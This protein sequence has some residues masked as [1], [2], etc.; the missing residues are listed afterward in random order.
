MNKT[1]KINGAAVDHDASPGPD[2]QR[3]KA[4]AKPRIVSR[5][6]GAVAQRRGAEPY[7]ALLWRVEARQSAD[8]GKS[9]TLGLIGCQRRVGVTTVAGNLAVRASELQLGPVLLVETS[10]T[11]A[12]LSREWRL[13][14]GPGFAQYLSGEASYAECLRQG[15]AEELTVLPAG[16][17]PR[18]EVSL[19]EPGAIDALLAEACADNRLVI[20][21]LPAADELQQLLLV[22]KQLD[23]ALL[24]VRSDSTRERDAQ[25]IADRL[26]EDGV[27]LS[28]AV[29]NRRR[30]YVPRWL[31][32]WM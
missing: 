4:P 19:V 16:T 14:P 9:A 29:L 1:M 11:R 23:Q 2:D 15:P 25:K 18:G 26:L 3:A 28:G 8:A 5:H 30:N 17:L 24:V 21:D 6:Q 12:R 22:A 10:P 31:Q 13:P 32:R 7:D 27:P 20:F